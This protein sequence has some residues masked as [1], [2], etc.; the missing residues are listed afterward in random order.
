MAA[1]QTPLRIVRQT[2]GSS[3]QR[4]GPGININNLKSRLSSSGHTARP[5][6]SASRRCLVVPNGARTGFPSCE[7]SHRHH[8]LLRCSVPSKA[9]QRR[10]PH[11]FPSDFPLCHCCPTLTDQT[12]FRHQINNTQ[13]PSRAWKPVVVPQQGRHNSV[14]GTVGDCHPARLSVG[15]GSAR[16]NHHELFQIFQKQLRLLQRR[17]MSALTNTSQH[18][19]VT[20]VAESTYLVMR[21][22]EGEV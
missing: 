5:C 21:L 8:H 10:I 7:G 17:I 16:N 2:V 4:I 18:L 13:H 12:Y 9:A 11:R 6:K 20:L 3:K 14:L 19:Q 15:A 22:V 1:T